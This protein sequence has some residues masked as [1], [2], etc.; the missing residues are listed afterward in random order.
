[1]IAM[2]ENPSIEEMRHELDTGQAADIR[3]Y[4]KMAYQPRCIQCGNEHP[5]WWYLQNGVRYCNECA[6][7]APK[8]EIA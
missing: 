3:F 6:S 8:R 7:G 1:M 5:A 2:D 4:R